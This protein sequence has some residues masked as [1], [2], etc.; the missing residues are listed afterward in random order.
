MFSKDS[1]SDQIAILYLYLPL[2]RTE[3]AN[4]VRLWNVNRIRT[5]PKRPS[6][7]TG[8]PYML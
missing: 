4:F 6:A 1:L 2:I 5:Q 3:L 7:L 8:K